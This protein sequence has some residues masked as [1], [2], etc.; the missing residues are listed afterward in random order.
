MRGTYR[1][2]ECGEAV[3]HIGKDGRRHITRFFTNYG[4]NSCLGCGE[5]FS[6]EWRIRRPFSQFVKCGICQIRC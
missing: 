4:H 6:K 2:P 5:P 3:S 1:C